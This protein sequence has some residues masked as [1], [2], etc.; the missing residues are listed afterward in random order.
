M[1]VYD[2]WQY[3]YA[4]ELQKADWRLQLPLKKCGEQMMIVF[5]DIYGNEARELIPRSR[6]D[7]LMNAAGRREEAIN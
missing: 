2:R 5:I 1:S 6:V 7:E 3:I 4:Q